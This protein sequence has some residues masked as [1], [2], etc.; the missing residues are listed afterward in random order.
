[1]GGSSKD[2]GVVEEGAGIEEDRLRL[3]K[4]FGEEG[5]VLRVELVGAVS[6]A[7]QQ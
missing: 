7:E 6:E 1:M 4:E 3:E 5:E 2:E